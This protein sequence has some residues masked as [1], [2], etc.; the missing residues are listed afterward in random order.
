MRCPRCGAENTGDL[1]LCK[2]CWLPLGER[3]TAPRPE[4]ERPRAAER[5]PTREPAPLFGVPYVE[6]RDDVAGAVAETRSPRYAESAMPRQS[7][8]EH[9]FQCE[10]PLSRPTPRAVMALVFGLLAI[11]LFQ[12]PTVAIPCDVLALV[13]GISEMSDVRQGRAPESSRNFAVPGIIL[14]VVASF[15]IMLVLVRI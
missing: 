4:A 8:I 3:Q 2:R 15:Y 12:L 9:S 14:A 6:R 13:L 5:R 11:L 1:A 7:I 10:H